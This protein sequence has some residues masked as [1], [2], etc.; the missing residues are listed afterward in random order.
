MKKLTA[1]IMTL[2]MVFS[3]VGCAPKNE[4]P[5]VEADST[6]SADI[7][8]VVADSAVMSAAN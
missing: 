2:A 7:V 5:A 8:I 4:V 3:M 1:I 6:K